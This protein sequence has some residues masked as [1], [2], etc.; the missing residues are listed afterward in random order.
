MLSTRI[1]RHSISLPKQIV[2]KRKGTTVITYWHYN[3][4]SFLLTEIYFSLDR[5]FN[6]EQSLSATSTLYDILTL[7]LNT[8]KQVITIELFSTLS[9]AASMTADTVA[10]VVLFHR[11]GETV[12]RGITRCLCVWWHAWNPENSLWFG[13]NIFSCTFTRTNAC[14]H[15]YTHFTLTRIK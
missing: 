4:N 3:D 2:V 5:I 11:T 14:T 1:D 9:T 13:R 12:S 7:N 10:D 8:N 6:G 15:T